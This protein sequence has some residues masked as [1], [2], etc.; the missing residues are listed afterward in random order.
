[1]PG[2]GDDPGLGHLFHSCIEYQ[3]AIMMSQGWSLLMGIDGSGTGTQR[4][5]IE[6]EFGGIIEEPWCV[7]VRFQETYENHGDNP[8][9]HGD[10]DRPTTGEQLGNPDRPTSGEELGHLCQDTAFTQ[11]VLVYCTCRTSARLLD[12]LPPRS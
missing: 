5:F 2:L 4:N 7:L 10:P 6:L 11:G 8:G 9:H 12:S 1:M 3:L